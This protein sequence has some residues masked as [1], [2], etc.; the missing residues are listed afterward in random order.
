MIEHKKVTTERLQ[1]EPSHE[2]INNPNIS[3]HALRGYDFAGLELMLQGGLQ[4]A[5]NQR[6]H[7]V[8]LSVS[9]RNAWSVNKE[10]NS[11]YAYTLQEGISLAV[12][13]G[14]LYPV[15]DHGGFL[16][17]AR[18][19]R[20]RA[21]QIIGVMLP[22]QASELPIS[23]AVALYESRKP[24]QAELYI[25]RTMNQL[26]DLGVIINTEDQLY[27]QNAVQAC[28]DGNYLSREQNARIQVVFMGYY[29]QYLRQLGVEHPTVGDMLQVV[30]DRAARQMSVY[31]WT[32]DQKQEV[33][34]MNARI[35]T[36]ARLARSALD[37]FYTPGQY[38]E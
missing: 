34:M 21:D 6:D 10:A 38:T 26:E 14:S 4:P 20:V 24:K 3:W 17:E 28:R 37:V 30:F 19:S 33:G 13:T 1:E 31:T 5:E 2:M 11:F 16:D 29:E 35:A 15:G 36:N 23:E 25:D 27:L 12:D 22:A 18:L 32:E 7:C 9:P 8:C